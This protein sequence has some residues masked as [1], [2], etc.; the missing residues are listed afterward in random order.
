VLEG[1]LVEE[2]LAVP[3]AQ[4]RELAPAAERD[5]LLDEV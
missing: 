4:D 1:L 3:R 2:R 5:C